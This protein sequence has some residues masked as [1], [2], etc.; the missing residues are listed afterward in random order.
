MVIELAGGGTG[1]IFAAYWNK[2]QN[3]SL[4]KYQRLILALTSEYLRFSL[5]TSLLSTANAAA[6]PVSTWPSSAVIWIW[7]ERQS[8]PITIKDALTLYFWK[9]S[10]I[11]ATA[12]LKDATTVDSPASPKSLY[13]LIAVAWVFASLIAFWVATIALNTDRKDLVSPRQNNDQLRCPL[14]QYWKIHGCVVIGF[15]KVLGQ[16]PALWH[17][18]NGSGIIGSS[19]RAGAPPKSNKFRWEISLQSLV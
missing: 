1:S 9:A 4:E 14:F 2:Y 16:L 6:S 11:L 15:S 13:S 12:V 3:N 17:Q 18:E 8:G 7:K 19:D 10:L 5:S